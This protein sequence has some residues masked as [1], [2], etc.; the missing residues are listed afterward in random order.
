[1]I[2]N[3]KIMPLQQGQVRLLAD[4]TQISLRG[5]SYLIRGTSGDWVKANANG[6]YLDVKV[7]LGQ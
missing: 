3:G 5:N 4:G 6:S 2:V 1:V 7:G